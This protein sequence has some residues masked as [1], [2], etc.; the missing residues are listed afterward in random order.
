M[1]SWPSATSFPASACPTMPGTQD[2]RFHARFLWTWV[3]FT[4]PLADGAGEVHHVIRVLST[5]NQIVVD[6]DR[7]VLAPDAT[8]LFHG[9]SNEPSSALWIRR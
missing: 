7:L 4:K 3:I 8:E 6:H 5:R 1:T 9:R 2:A